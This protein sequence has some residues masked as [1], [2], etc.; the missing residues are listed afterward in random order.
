LLS[1]S[2]RLVEHHLVQDATSDRTGGGRT[3]ATNVVAGQRIAVTVGRH[4]WPPGAAAGGQPQVW[5][6]TDS[7]GTQADVLHVDR[8]HY[9]AAGGRG[10]VEVLIW[11]DRGVIICGPGSRVQLLA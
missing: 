9:T 6:T 8:R 2:A 4:R 1:G 7:A 11:T 3:T 10:R 5:L